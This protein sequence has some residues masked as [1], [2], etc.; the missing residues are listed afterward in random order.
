MIVTLE[1]GTMIFF[2]DKE[3][4]TEDKE[5]GTSTGFDSFFPLCV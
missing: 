2:N 4:G 3:D 1:V 5:P